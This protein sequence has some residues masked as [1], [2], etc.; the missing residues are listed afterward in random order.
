MAVQVCLEE[1]RP[2]PHYLNWQQDVYAPEQGA[3]PR[4]DQPAPLTLDLRRAGAAR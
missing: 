3:D 4:R 1:A 2:Q